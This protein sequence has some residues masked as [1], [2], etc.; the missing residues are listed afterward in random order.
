VVTN[1][2]LTPKCALLS[3][4]SKLFI[5][6]I[7]CLLLLNQNILFK[8]RNTYFLFSVQKFYRI[9]IKSSKALI[10]LYYSGPKITSLVSSLK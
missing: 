3:V 5:S 7:F 1:F 9:E 8:G 4:F 6:L 10:S 2:F